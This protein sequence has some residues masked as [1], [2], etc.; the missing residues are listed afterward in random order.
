MRSV[1]CDKPYILHCK[2]RRGSRA[3]IIERLRRYDIV[4]RKV[5]D[6][7][8]D[9]INALDLGCGRGEW[10]ELAEKEYGVY[11]MG[12]DNDS[13]MLAVCKENDLR[14]L[15]ADLV[16]YVKNAA[17][18]SVNI[19]SL[20][21]VAEHLPVSVLSGVL[22]ECFRVLRK[23]GALI[24]ETPNPENMIVGS[25]NFFFDPT[26]VSKIPPSLMKILAEGAGFKS[27]E[28]VRLHEYDA[29]DTSNLSVEDVAEKQM[30]TFFNNYGDYAVIAYKEG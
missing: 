20:F 25:C 18:N 2:N 27:I 8:D 7:V 11:A 13:S 21:Q 6:G 19:V 16:E 30:A 14:V 17:S 3:E 23:G 12:V 22:N 26:H 10:L 9:S 5:K 24:V 4:F 1:I 28:I 15:K 29:I